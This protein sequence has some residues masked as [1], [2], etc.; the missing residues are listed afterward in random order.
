MMEAIR[1]ERAR[2][3]LEEERERVA[4]DAERIRERCRSLSGFIREAWHILEPNNAYVHGWHIDAIAQHLEAVT[5]G[6]ISRLIINEPP[7][8][9]KSLIVS[10]FWPAWEWGP[11]DRSSLRY[12]TTSYS[13][14]YVKRD[15]RRM[16][17]LVASDW[18][19]ALWPRVELVR[20]G[21]TSFANSQTGFRE[22]V[23]F[24]SLTAGRGDRLIIDDPHSTETAES[25]AERARTIRIFRESVPTRLIDPMRSAI[26]IM[27]Q[28]LHTSDVTGVALALGLGYEH[29]MLPM[30]F[31]PER[32]CSTSI[33]FADPRTYD[34][35][36][37]FPER[38]PREVVDRDK[39]PMG[40]YA[41]AGQFQQRP[42]AREGGLFKRHWFDGKLVGSAPE[43][44][45]WV[46]RWDLAATK[47]KT[48]ARTAGVKLGVSMSSGRFYVGHVVTT[49]DEG[50]AV[51]TLIKTTADIDGPTVEISLPQDPGQAGKVQAQDLVAMLAGFIVHAQPETGDKE[52]RAKPFAAQC[53]AGNVFL[54]EAGWNEGYLDEICMFPSGNFKDQVDASSGA[55]AQFVGVDRALTAAERDLVCDPLTL[56]PEWPRVY[57]VA[58]SRDRVGVVWGAFNKQEDTVY[59]YAE[60]AAPRADL[61]VHAAAIRDRAKWVPGV[62]APK[63]K[64]RTLEEGAAIVARLEELELKL[65]ASGADPDA[66]LEQAAQRIAANRLRVFRNMSGW[67]A[68]FRTFRRDERGKLIGEGAELMAATA[69]LCASG[70]D[71]A[72]TE[73]KKARFRSGQTRSAW[74][75]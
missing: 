1:K 53:E 72:I 24:A 18:Y 14:N 12:L 73:P 43:D 66:A 57:S 36:L 51:R 26:V 11:C 7:G 58:M 41:V 6:R 19:R 29:L 27:M 59:L 8:T 34:G 4:H 28:R 33:G 68:E 65:T 31:E 22:G 69:L 70:L 45:R 64:D 21:E 42:T 67:I 9:M 47:K 25:D 20:S 62:F 60:Y 17:D 32:R 3:R 15:A 30:E 63:V 40:S 56:P 5:D 48:A 38:F 37:L 23:P 55:F 10:V 61:A 75:V 50:L 74:G 13:E 46:R 44:I 2:R 35:E 49:Q 16:R 71:A 39:V 52:T 54:V